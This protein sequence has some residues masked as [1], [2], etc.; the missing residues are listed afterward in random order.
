MWFIIQRDLW[1]SFPSLKVIIFLLL[2]A[3]FH[4]AAQ[5]KLTYSLSHL[6]SGPL[7]FFGP[8]YATDCL[9]RPFPLF[10]LSS[11]LVPSVVPNLGR[12]CLWNVLISSSL[13][14]EHRQD[15]S[16]YLAPHKD[17]ALLCSLVWRGKTARWRKGLVSH[18]VCQ[19]DNMSSYHW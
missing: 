16:K 11:H 9:L 14:A 1:Q 13:G 2:Q 10:H 19:G 12:C 17:S 4:S 7:I 3:A 6:T 15:S 18:G 5:P 8:W